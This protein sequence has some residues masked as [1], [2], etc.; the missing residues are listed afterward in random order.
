MTIVVVYPTIQHHKFLR[1]WEPKMKRFILLICL[2]VLL[3]INGVQAAE[4]IIDI[5]GTQI[6][7]E[8]FGDSNNPA[9]LLIMGGGCQGIHWPDKFC[10]K[11]ANRG[12]F[13]IRYDNRDTGQS[14]IFPD[15]ES[16]YSLLDMAQDAVGVLDHYAISKARIIG[17]SMG[18]TIAQL[19]AEHFPDRVER[20]I[21]IGGTPNLMPFLSAFEGKAAQDSLPA[22]KEEYLQSIKDLM[23]MDANAPASVKVENHLNIWR[24]CNGSKIPFEE[25]LYRKIIVRAIERTRN[26]NVVNNHFQAIRRTFVEQPPQLQKI[27]APTIVIHGG[28]DPIFAKEHGL[29]MVQLI[30]GAK[31]ILIED[32]G[33]ILNSQFYD[34]IIET[35]CTN[36]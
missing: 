28:Q 11:L 22:P 19:V 14:S 24:I 30:P 9:M 13:V 2:Q 6:W 8:T 7:T 27:S 20:L 10:E 25:D 16:P 23:S 12:F 26:E 34:E 3:L 15:T 32:M 18:S 4:K 21:L 5:N 35:A 36:G 17:P 29:A 33:H 1:R 31:L